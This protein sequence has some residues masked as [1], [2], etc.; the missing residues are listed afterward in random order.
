MGCGVMTIGLA[1]AR[2]RRRALVAASLLVLAAPPTLAS[3]AAA[4][5]LAPDLVSDPPVQRASPE[6]YSDA[7]GSRLLLRMDGF[8]HNRGPG[9]LEIRGSAPANLAMTSVVQR[10][11][12]DAGGFVDSTSTPAPSVLFETADG[13]SHWHLKHAVRYSLWSADGS[14]E[15]APAQKVG[16]CLVDSQPVDATS[17][18]AVYSTGANE[19]CAMLRPTAPEVYMGVSAGW[20]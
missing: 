13:H 6:L 17:Q 14:T 8:V 20:R 7:Q 12:D 3:A 1:R 2:A 10:L 11:Y 18:P 16:F 4:A 9:A 5:P 15:V 19:F